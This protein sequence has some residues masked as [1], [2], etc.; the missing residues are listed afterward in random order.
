MNPVSMIFMRKYE[1]QSMDKNY[2]IF[3]T[4]WFEASWP[5]L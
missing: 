5:E 2:L 4:I 3:E 1:I